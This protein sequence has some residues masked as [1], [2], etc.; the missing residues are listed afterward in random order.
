MNKVIM[1]SSEMKNLA[2]TLH[3]IADR[4]WDAGDA[5]LARKVTRTRRTIKRKA[6]KG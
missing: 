5:K 3:L 1:S 2:M 6:N 4:L